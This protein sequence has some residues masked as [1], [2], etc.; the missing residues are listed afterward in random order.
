MTIQTRNHCFAARVT[1]TPLRRFARGL[2]AACLLALSSAGPALASIEA[3]TSSETPAAGRP[4]IVG[5]N[6]SYPPYEFLDANG[7]PAGYNVDLTRAIADVMGM[8]VEFRFD[9]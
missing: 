1:A 3:P 9:A 6:R 5:G 7:K 2:L 8:K 4:I